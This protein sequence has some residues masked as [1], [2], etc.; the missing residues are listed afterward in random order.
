MSAIKESWKLQFCEE[1][2]GFQMQNPQHPRVFCVVVVIIKV[3]IEQYVFGI[4]R[5]TSHIISSL[6]RLAENRKYLL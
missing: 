1:E 3:I 5:V 4:L 2:L 6:L